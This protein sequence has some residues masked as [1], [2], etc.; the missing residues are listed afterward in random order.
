M[1]LN[2]KRTLAIVAKLVDQFSQPLS[3]M[4]RTLTTFRAGLKTALAG[5]SIAMGTVV[6]ASAAGFRALLQVA[7]GLGKITDAAE[8]LGLTVESLTAIRGGAELA[9]VSVEQLGVAMKGFQK[10]VAEANAGSDKQR[11]LLEALGLQAKDFAGN[12]LD[13]VDVLAQVADGLSGVESAAARTR[14]LVDLFGKSGVELGGLLKQGAAGIRQLEQNARSMGAVFSQE[15]LQRVKD[16]EN[17]WKALGQTFR[18]IVERLVVD[19]APALADFFRDLREGLTSNAGSVREA[20]LA[21][22]ESLLSGIK[23]ITDALHGF[24]LAIEGFKAITDVLFVEKDPAKAKSISEALQERADRIRAL[25]EAA[26]AAGASLD[27]LAT[28]LANIRRGAPQDL[29]PVNAL[30]PDVPP[31][32]PDPTAFQ[33][34]F[35]GFSA[36]IDKVIEKWRDFGTAGKEAA[37]AIVDGGLD[38]L[39]DSLAEVGRSIN[40][41]SEFAESF[42]KAF[43][44]GLQ[45]VIAKL[46]VMQGLELLLGAER[47]GVLPATEGLELG[48][49]KRYAGGGLNRRGG[50]ARRPTV[51]FGEGS[52]AE[53][54]VPLPDNRSIPVTLTGG[55]AGGTTIVF[56][57]TAM[58]GRDVQ[59]VLIEQQNTLRAINENHI[60]TK[61]G[62]RR[63][64]Q[65]VA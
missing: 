64:I 40:S 60:Q 27:K 32:P 38:A 4:Q 57:I 19:L 50:I 47:G 43:A 59:R 42:T 3:R 14:I 25:N 9:G 6:A 61:V 52:T 23:T 12:Q 2:E 11:D 65:R 22:S 7:D 51:M 48:G 49:I 33:K 18:A 29:P 34:F 5:A 55:G 54:F 10:V 35:A 1:A 21:I 62:M 56:N 53:A 17:S 20:M 26:N 8:N 16:F 36:G 37:I 39:V 45:K 44:A 46:L 28:R 24:A 31:K 63:V 15:E 41:L 30:P 58:D 13:V